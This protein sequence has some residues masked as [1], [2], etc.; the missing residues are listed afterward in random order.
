MTA[1][2]GG[3]GLVVDVVSAALLLLGVALSLV[4][5]AGL[6]RFPDL[7][8][9]M[10][11]ATKPSTLGL[12]LVLAGTGLQL[13][14]PGDVVELLLVAAFQLVTAPV[15]AHMIGRASYRAGVPGTRSAQPDELAA[16]V[17]R[18]LREEREQREQRGQRG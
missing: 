18:E 6:V 9:R 13:A 12:L 1:D 5:S 16:T 14:D 4:A 11:A 8:S 3:V 17:E 15:A 10:H 2:T 7:Y